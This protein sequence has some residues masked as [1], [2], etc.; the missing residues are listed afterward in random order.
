MDI[1]KYLPQ[2]G[3]NTQDVSGMPVDNS[4]MNLQLKR[5]M[6]F[7]DALREQQMPQGQMIGDRFV[8]PSWT[9]Q[10]AN[11]VGKMTGAY[12]EKKALD[13]YKDFQKN[14]TSQLS[15]LLRG[16]KVEESIPGTE[17][18][19]MPGMVQE[20]YKPYSRDEFLSKATAI[21]PELGDEMV[22]A[23]VGSYF[24]EDQPVQ[25]G[26]GGVLVNRKGEVIARNPKSPKFSDKYS[27][28]KVD[29]QSGKTFG[30]N[31]ETMKVEQIPGE[32]LS[33]KPAAAPHVQTF[34][35]DGFYVDKQWNPQT[36]KYDMVSR[37]P[38]RQGG[39]GGQNKPPAGYQWTPQGTLAAI[40]GGPGDPNTKP[41]TQDQAN[42]RLY[43]SRMS[44]SHDILSGLEQ[45]GKPSYNPIAIKTILTMPSAI[46]E[47]T[48]YNASE[49]T[50]SAAQAMRNFINATLRRESGA[51]ITPPE[52][53][54]AMKQYFPQLG[55]KP[56]VLAQKRANRETAIAGIAAAGY[57]GG[58][59][60]KAETPAAPASDTGVKVPK[61]KSGKI[62]AK[63]LVNGTNYQGLGKWNAK[64]QSFE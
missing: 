40:P 33:A 56:G 37:S 54:N 25:L 60:P 27:N 64:T 16:K 15:D 4:L 17:E 35:E 32:V 9:Q 42:A 20:T 2:F 55:D 59:A 24:K 11:A 58:V 61:D 45:G 46:S 10:L 19:N 41:L 50:Q 47:L 26:E 57:P 52:F 34:H 22:K 28:I 23:Q 1:M 5:R 12:Q 53:D 44:Q 62:N 39:E 51:T 38:I 13:Q 8:A 21:M 18:M 3:D 7:A 29:E 30:I 14:K 43:S 36:Q 31:N 63:L 48:N 49:E 6:A